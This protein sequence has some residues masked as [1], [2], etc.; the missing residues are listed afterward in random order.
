MKPRQPPRDTATGRCQFLRDVAGGF[1]AK[2]PPRNTAEVFSWELA[3]LKC[4]ECGAEYELEARYVCERCFGPLEVAYDH[5]DLAADLDELRRRIQAA[6]RTSGATPTS[7]R[8][9]A[10]PGPSRARVVARRPAGRLHAADPRRPARRA[11]RPARGLGQERRRQPHALVQGP[12]RLA[13]PRTRARELG[14]D[15]ARLRLDRQPRQ[16]GRRPRRRA[17]PGDLRLHPGRPRGAEDPRDRRLRHEPRQGQAATTTTSTASAP[18]SRASATGRSSTSTCARTTPRA[19]RR[20]PTRSP[21]SSAGET[22]DRVVAPIASGS[23]YTKIAKGFDEWLE[24]GPH[25]RRRCRR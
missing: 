9:P 21:S 4:R 14:F 5:G 11:P 18:S 19:P 12:R 1:Q 17:R 16:L 24:L 2:P 7:C 20:S 3:A 13:S 8:S 25:Q 10:P 23:L 22:P 6:R 15:V